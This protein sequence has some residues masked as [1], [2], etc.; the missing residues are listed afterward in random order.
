LSGRPAV[1]LCARPAYLY[2]T[3]HLVARSPS[4]EKKHEPLGEATRGSSNGGGAAAGAPVRV[5]EA[6]ITCRRKAEGGRDRGNNKCQMTNDKWGARAQGS[7]G[8][9]QTDGVDLWTPSAAP[10]SRPEGVSCKPTRDTRPR[11]WTPG[12]RPLRRDF[13]RRFYPSHLPI[14]SFPPSH[15]THP[16]LPPLPAPVSGASSASQ[17]ATPSVPYTGP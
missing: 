3:A 9:R 6:L 16:P 8:T 11:R 4:A 13:N 1:A 7:R 15:P 2:G 17:Y 10:G 14:P 12:P 5:G